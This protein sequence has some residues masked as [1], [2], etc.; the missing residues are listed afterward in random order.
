MQNISDICA[1]ASAGVIALMGIRKVIEICGWIMDEHIER[2]MRM[3]RI[4]ARIEKIEQIINFN[5]EVDID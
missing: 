1:I 4:E 5:K 2:E 3:N